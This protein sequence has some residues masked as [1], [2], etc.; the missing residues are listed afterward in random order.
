[1][2]SQAHVLTGPFL[3]D[4]H[5]HIHSCYPSDRLLDIARANI[6]AGA[7]G[8]GAP[9]DAL[10][11]L[12]LTESSGDDFFAALLDGSSAVEVGSWRLESDNEE[13]SVLARLDDRPA[14]LLIAGRQIATREGLEVLALGS[15]DRFSDGRSLAE[16]IEAVMAAGAITVIP[17]GFGKWWFAR[18]R[19]LDR[20]LRSPM[21]R[22][23]LLGDNGGRADLFPR[24]PL[25]A[26]AARRGLPILPGSD[27][28]PF[29]SEIS[30]IGS[31]GFVL[32]G[33]LNLHS[34]AAC[35]K[36]LI[37]GL[38]GQPPVFGRS[39]NLLKFA[40]NQFRLRLPS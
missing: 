27:P 31:Y 4:A 10:G 3:V 32:D 40:V 30:R 19:L 38:K 8:Q 9:V 22:S 20:Y 21:G 6:T 25:F 18:G 14:L 36:R 37:E 34:P 13:T 33:S 39:A 28:L 12:L 23:V 2:S 15:R 24:P 11:C 35:L 29:R 16:T 1:M 5:V 26:A 17:W 7:A